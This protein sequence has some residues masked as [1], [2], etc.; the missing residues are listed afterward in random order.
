MFLEH[1]SCANNHVTKLSIHSRYGVGGGGAKELQTLYIRVVSF[2]A[3]FRVVMQRI[4]IR[5]TEERV[6][7]LTMYY[8]E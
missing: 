5:A 2:A 4:N 3:V 8:C 7:S 6:F 1:V